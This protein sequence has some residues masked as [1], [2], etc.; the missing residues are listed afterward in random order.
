MLPESRLDGCGDEASAWIGAIRFDDSSLTP[1]ITS[2]NICAAMPKPNLIDSCLSR[3]TVPFRNGKPVW[4][5]R[6]LRL[7]LEHLVRRLAD[8]VVGPTGDHP[9]SEWGARRAV[10]TEVLKACG[11][12]ESGKK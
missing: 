7:T 2:V 6:A 9:P 3:V 10:R 1:A 5:E 12:K 11:L 4:N 8:D